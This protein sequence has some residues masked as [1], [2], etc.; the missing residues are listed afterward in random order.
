[1]A[2]IH[3]LIRGLIFTILLLLYLFR[4]ESNSNRNDQFNDLSRERAEK[5]IYF[6]GQD[7]ENLYTEFERN[8]KVFS[9]NVDA[10]APGLRNIYE[11]IERLEEINSS[12]PFHWRVV[13][14]QTKLPTLNSKGQYAL[15]YWLN[16]WLKQSRFH[17]SH[18][19]KATAFYVD[20]RCTALKNTQQKR[21]PSQRVAQLYIKKLVENIAMNMSSF[22]QRMNFLDHFYVCSHDMGI[23]SIRSTPLNFRTNAVGVVHTADFIGNDA[24]LTVWNTLKDILP[25]GQGGLIFNAHR[26]LT[27]P[28][29]MLS[30]NKNTDRIKTFGNCEYLAMFMGSTAGRALRGRM[31]SL[32][33]NHSE[34]LLGSAHGSE[35][36]SA[37]HRS[38]FCIVARGL[39]TSTLR[40]TEV[41][42]HSCVPVIISDGYIPPFSSSIDWRTFSVVVPE[43]EIG[44]LAKILGSINKRKWDYLNRNLLQVRKHFLYNNPPISGDCF[45]MILYE[46]WKK[47]KFWRHAKF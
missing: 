2:K 14:K 24:A 43:E 11:N 21:V 22:V 19:D 29:Y 9:Y 5:E 45:H 13:K 44:H 33:S 47:V 18:P 7:F 34:F 28:P 6:G 38:K 4:N 41:F 36:I 8:F 40:F 27:A 15:E 3:A 39:V 26:D 16:I 46:V 35:Y 31:F 30:I 32:F 17:T 23:E 1:M 25:S 20:V 12:F 37:F 10:F 42:I